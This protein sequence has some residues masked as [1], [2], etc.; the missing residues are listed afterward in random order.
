MTLVVKIRYCGLDLFAEA[1]PREVGTAAFQFSPEL[2]VRDSPWIRALGDLGQEDEST[3]PPALGPG[4]QRRHGSSDRAGRSGLLDGVRHDWVGA[5][6]W[7]SVPGRG[8]VS[9]SLPARGRPAWP[10]AT[11]PGPAPARGGPGLPQA[12][13]DQ[14]RGGGALLC[15]QG[16]DGRVGL[17]AADGRD[18]GSV[19]RGSLAADGMA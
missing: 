17:E 12:A 3:S 13:V 9:S 1:F 18:Q 16:E 14:D 19:S 10:S 4:A 5:L 15:G 6:G 2:P 8:R 11:A 7:V